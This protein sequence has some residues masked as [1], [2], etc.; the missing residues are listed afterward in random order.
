MT[1]EEAAQKIEALLAG[2]VGQ[3]LFMCVATPV[4]IESRWPP[5]PE[6]GLE[7]LELMKRLEAEGRVFACGPL[8]AEDGGRTADGLIILRVPD[9]E[10]A[11]ELMAGDPFVREGYR[12]VEIRPWRQNSWLR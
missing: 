7:H 1:Q 8:L 5:P 10:E 4:D 11:R 6:L 9:I 2:A 3:T 12:S